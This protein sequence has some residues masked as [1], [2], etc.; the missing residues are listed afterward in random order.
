MLRRLVSR[1]GITRHCAHNLGKVH[2]V[3]IQILGPL[4][5]M[6][7][8]VSV[9][10]SAPK[11]RQVLAVLALN[12]NRTVSTS[13]LVEELWGDRPPVS[14][15]TTLQTYIYQL[16]RW[17][18]GVAGTTHSL[19]TRPC[20][21]RLA[22]P[23]ED[24]DVHEFERLIAVGT[25]HLHEGDPVAAA[26][27]LQQALLSWRDQ[28]LLD[29]PT[30]SV[31]QSE[32]VRLN[33]MRQAALE[34]S[35]DAELQLGHCQQVVAAITAELARDPNHEG[36]H[37]RL[38]VALYRCGRRS[39]A[40]AVYQQIRERLAEELGLDPGPELQ[41]IHR[42]VLDDTMEPCSPAAVP[43][44]STSR[45]LGSP[46][47][48]LPPNHELSG[49]E[50]ELAWFDHLLHTAPTSQPLVLSVIGA[51]GVGFPHYV[52]MPRT[53]SEPNIRTRSS[54]PTS[55]APATHRPSWQISCAPPA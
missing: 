21:Y 38:M 22:G 54:T 6:N 32:V 12:A 52:C 37:G 5:V 36:M 45:H 24:L 1:V 33:S 49:R 43:P 40:L 18:S 3:K 46:P 10:P 7:A 13:R 30:G 19:E 51:P 14:W 26:G 20:G 39:D 35:L 2:L 11:V 16:R 15:A 55:P 8:G 41:K 42:A 23:A 27:A 29:L 17:L 48:Q 44:S 28:P 31:L 25:T 9:V 4:E 34:A 47:A 53:E 50:T